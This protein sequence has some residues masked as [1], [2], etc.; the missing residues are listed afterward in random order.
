MVDSQN[1]NAGA[2]ALVWAD[3]KRAS[4]EDVENALGEA[5]GGGAAA[6]KGGKAP[7]KGA[8]GKGAAV[9]EGDVEAGTE[10][11]DFSKPVTYNLVA[12]DAKAND[13]AQVHNI[14]LAGLELLVRMDL[15]YAQY[16]SFIAGDNE[17]SQQV[18]ET[19]AKLLARVLD[20]SP[21][22]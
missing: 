2:E 21:Q 14:Y 5:S 20:P 15:R 22:L 13:S 18:L 11:R 7:A 10:E 4:E 19:V 6:G 12:P 9:E 3:R 17:K 1:I 16:L 8:P